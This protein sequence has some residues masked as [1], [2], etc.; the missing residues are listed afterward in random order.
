MAPL[1]SN[2]R[3]NRLKA[4]IGGSSRSCPYEKHD[5]VSFF[6]GKRSLP[7]LCVASCHAFRGEA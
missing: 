5:I 1:V 4:G 3:S 7:V 2:V 6:L